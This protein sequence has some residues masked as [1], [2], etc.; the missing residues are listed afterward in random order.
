VS[1]YAYALFAG[2]PDGPP[3]GVWTEKW[4]FVAWW[5]KTRPGGERLNP[6]HYVLL[7]YRGD[8]PP[9]E[10]NVHDVVA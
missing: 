8:K 7:R 3:I 4:L 2:D 9:V 1:G 5:K 10:M 6:E